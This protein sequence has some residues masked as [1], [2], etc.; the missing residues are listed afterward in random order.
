MQPDSV[1]GTLARYVDEYKSDP[2]FIAQGLAVKVTDEALHILHA[3]GL[4]QSWMAEAMQVSPAHVSRVLNAPPNLT[5]L[6]IAKMAVALGVTPD[7]R[8]SSRPGEVRASGSGP[9]A[10]EDWVIDNAPPSDLRAFTTTDSYVSPF[11]TSVE[12]IPANAAS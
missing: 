9:S 8:L 7:V 3:K 1:D 10:L 11:G 4:P 12:G 2:E 6:S 5:L